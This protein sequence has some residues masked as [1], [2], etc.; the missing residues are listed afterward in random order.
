MYTT[1]AGLNLNIRNGNRAQWPIKF[2]RYKVAVEQ[3]VLKKKQLAR[4]LIVQSFSKYAIKNNG[5]TSA[6]ESV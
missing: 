6:K 1:N 4:R 5:V 2:P 3:V